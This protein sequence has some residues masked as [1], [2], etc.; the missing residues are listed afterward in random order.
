M[1]EP[2]ALHNLLREWQSPEPSPEFDRRV[3]NAYREA[4]RPPIWRRFWRARISIPMPVFAI[5]ALVAVA[6]LLW[7]R[8]SST[9]PAPAATSDL[10][11]HLNATGFRPLPDGAARVISVTE[12]KK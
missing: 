8:W 11:T 6:L 12:L 4:Q 9:P 5:G 10:V 3:I 7:F 2:D 1:R